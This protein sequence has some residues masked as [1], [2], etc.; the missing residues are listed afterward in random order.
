VAIWSEMPRVPYS[1][2]GPLLRHEL[3]HAAQWDRHGRSYSELDGYL[4]EAWDASRHPERYLRLPSEREAN[5]AAAKY[6]RA[7]LDDRHLRRLRRSRRYRQLVDEDAPQLENDSLSLTVDAL[8]EVRDRFLPQL[9]ADGRERELRGL[10]R[11]AREWRPGMLDLLRDETA[12][13]VVVV[14]EPYSSVPAT[15][16]NAESR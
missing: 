16:A 4:R 9:D 15:E 12:A 6:A 10:E 3:E 11:N 7:S 13:E 5:L 1:I 8:Q 2:L 14:T